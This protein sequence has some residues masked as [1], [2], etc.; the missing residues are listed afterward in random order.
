MGI[1]SAF[2][3]EQG[4]Q[5][6]GLHITET[7]NTTLTE[8]SIR[9]LEVVVLAIEKRNLRRTS[10]LT[11]RSRRE[12]NLYKVTEE[13]ETVTLMTKNIAELRGKL[14]KIPADL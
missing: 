14:I 10:H 5:S 12:N 2:F 4:K 9:Y 13:M 6:A 3:G 1:A 11:M 8:I 7:L